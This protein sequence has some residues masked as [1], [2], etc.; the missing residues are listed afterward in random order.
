MEKR[1]ARCNHLLTKIQK[2]DEKALERLFSE[3]GAFF[4]HVAKFYLADKSLADDV[5]SE[6]FVEIVKTSARS[7]DENKNG[8]NWIY[9]IIKRKAYKQNGTVFAEESY[10]CDEKTNK[11]LNRYTIDTNEDALLVKEA[12]GRLSE[13]ENAILYCKFWEGLTVREIAKRLDKPKSNV[14]Y[15]I[16]SALSKVKEY[17]EDNEK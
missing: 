15:K 6:V 4:L 7:F 17:L 16:E 2:G 10:D 14:Q 13:E 11:L 5:L 8:I 12:L 9:T 3:F 1:I